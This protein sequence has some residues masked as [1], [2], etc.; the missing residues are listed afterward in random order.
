MKGKRFLRPWGPPE[1]KIY[2]AKKSYTTLS[3]SIHMT[4]EA[5]VKKKVVKI[6]EDNGAYVVSIV[7]GGYG[8][9]GVPDIIACFR[10]SFWA[11]ECKA[12]N[13]K[14]TALQDK[15]ISAIRIACGRAWIINEQTL[16]TFEDAIKAHF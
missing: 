2:G 1:G 8:K 13:G 15:N 16:K 5:K 6:L 9:N 11:I 14:L 4:P 7:T 3:D 10:G 12:G